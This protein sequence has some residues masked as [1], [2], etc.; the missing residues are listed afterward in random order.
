MVIRIMLMVPV[1]AVS[2]L[3]SLFSLD[4]AFIIDVIRDVYEVRYHS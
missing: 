1:Y 2:S 4:A 3:I